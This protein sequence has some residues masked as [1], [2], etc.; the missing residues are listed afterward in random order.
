MLE[1]QMVPYVFFGDD[2]S[3]EAR[4]FLTAISIYKIWIK[5][6]FV[7]TIYK[8]VLNVW[9]VLRSNDPFTANELKNEILWNNRF[10]KIGGKSFFYSSW[11]KKGITKI[12]HLNF[13]SRSEFQLK[14]GLSVNFH[15]YNGLLFAIPADAW[16][17]SIS[18][19]EQN[20]IDVVSNCLT[21]ANVT[22]KNA[23]QT[24]ALRSMKPPNAWNNFSW[25]E[26]LYTSS[27]WIAIQ[28]YNCKQA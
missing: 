5:K 24:H 23:R 12:F 18:N 10:I 13:L 6:T 17:R 9:K 11:Y 20:S 19:P 27:L 7:P 25:K 22:A 1:I 14:Y 15:M 4:S 26:S 3:M 16:K 21:L 8:E 28:G 2:P